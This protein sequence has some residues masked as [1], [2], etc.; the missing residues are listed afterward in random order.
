[1][2][3]G[4]NGCGAVQ[5]ARADDVSPVPGDEATVSSGCRPGVSRSGLP[6]RPRLAGENLHRSPEGLFAEKAALS[7]LLPLLQMLGGPRRR[8]CYRRVGR[9]LDT[10][11]TVAPIPTATMTRGT[12]FEV[13]RAMIPTLS[14]NSATPRTRNMQPAN[15][16]A[17][18]E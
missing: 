1:Q 3:A 10:P 13:R 15:R 18:C 4:A 7:C 17:G 2:G 5:A 11:R 8:R 9:T 6:A 12:R 14:R 16:G